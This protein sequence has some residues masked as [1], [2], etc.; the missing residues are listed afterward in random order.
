MDK[1]DSRQRKDLLKYRKAAEQTTFF[2]AISIIFLGLIFMT[3][4]RE[5]LLKQEILTGLGAA[6]NLCIAI[7][8]SLRKD[9]VFVSVALAAAIA[10]VVLLVLQIVD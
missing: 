10:P 6:L 4:D 2:L 1:D 7:E 3:R 9:W 5:I 8:Q